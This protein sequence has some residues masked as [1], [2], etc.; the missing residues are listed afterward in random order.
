MSDLTDAKIIEIVKFNINDGVNYD[1][2]APLD[3]AL[4]VQHVSKQPGFVARHAA[5]GEDG[6]WLVV[7][8]WASLDAAD[9]SMAS[10]MDAPAAAEFVAHLDGDT[11]SMTR[12]ER[13]KH[14]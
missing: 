4:E 10:F 5:K 2:F 8:Y 3:R 9:A 13:V 7:V 11:M 1:Q 14:S 6:E 12:F